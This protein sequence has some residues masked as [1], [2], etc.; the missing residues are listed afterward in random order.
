LFVFGAFFKKGDKI[1]RPTIPKRGT[2]L[3]CDDHPQTTSCAQEAVKLMPSLLSEARIGAGLDIETVAKKVG[4]S[5]AYLRRI[6]NGRGTCSYPLARKLIRL[7]GCSLNVFLTKSGQSDAQRS[8][9]NKKARFTSEVKR[10]K[11]SI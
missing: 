2:G 5:T 9:K 10:A 1:E 3:Q 7:Y 11:S 6:E 8:T 4:C